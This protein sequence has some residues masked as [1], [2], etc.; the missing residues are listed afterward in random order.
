MQNS[1]LFK[2]KGWQAESFS[3]TG[4]PKTLG[5]IEGPQSSD[6]RCETGGVY[7]GFDSLA[8]FAA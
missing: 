1:S 5:G 4:C 7:V 8:L 3:V 6:F 2:T